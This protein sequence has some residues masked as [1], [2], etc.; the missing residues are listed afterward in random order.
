MYYNVPDV[1]HEGDVE[2]ERYA[3]VKM[4]AKVVE[5]EVF[6]GDEEIDE[7]TIYIEV[8]ASEVEKF[9]D[10]DCHRLW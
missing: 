8:D 1:E 7:A 6:Y 2:S 9:L 5:T 3:L 4:G 10:Y